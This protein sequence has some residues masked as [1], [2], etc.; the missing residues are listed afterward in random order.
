[1]YN[2]ANQTI[3]TQCIC[4]NSTKHSCLSHCAH[5]AV[6]PLHPNDTNFLARTLRKVLLSEIEGIAITRVH[7][8]NTV[9]EC[10]TLEGIQESVHHIFHEYSKLEGIQES[11]HDILLNLKDIV[12]KGDIQELTTGFLSFQGPGTMTAEHIQLPSNIKVVDKTQYI[13]Y[14]QQ[15]IK[16]NIRL[17][18]ERGKQSQTRTNVETN[19]STFLLDTKFTP[20]NK[21]NF[22]I[23][24]FG[25]IGEKY[26]PQQMMLLEICTNGA[27]NPEEALLD[28]W[29]SLIRLPWM[30]GIV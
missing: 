23:Y 15:P 25:K 13:A 2:N 22:S 1:M 29:Y 19:N 16:V 8:I 27:L 14:V 9:H 5:F 26:G 12:L 11:V 28:A 7:F 30:L 3:E 4:L 17:F 6:F 18:I 24:S 10:S 21:V 20:I